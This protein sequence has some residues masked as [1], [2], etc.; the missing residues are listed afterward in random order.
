MMMNPMSS[1]AAT[2]SRST[3]SK[4]NRTSRRPRRLLLGAMN[5]SGRREK[6][7]N[8][9]SKPPTAA[10]LHGIVHRPLCECGGQTVYFGEALMVSLRCDKCAQWLMGAGD[11]FIETINLRWIRGD[12]GYVKE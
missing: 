6:I 10:P 5:V 11:E 9:P 1:Q 12:R 7:M 3:H 2:E 4:R 8:E